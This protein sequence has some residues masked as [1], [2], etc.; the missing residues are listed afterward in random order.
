M[1]STDIFQ[2]LNDFLSY[3]EKFI[4]L[5]HD[6][7]RARMRACAGEARGKKRREKKGGKKKGGK[8]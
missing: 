7:L 6:A 1:S 5:S 4:S 3:E 2:A 8:A